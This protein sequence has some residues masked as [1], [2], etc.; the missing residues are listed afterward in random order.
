MLLSQRPKIVDVG[1]SYDAPHDIVS[2]LA[3][4]GERLCR[5]IAAR[6]LQGR[7]VYI[8]LAADIEGMPTNSWA[9]GFFDETHG[10][11]L[12]DAIG[13]RWRGPGVSLVID[14]RWTRFKA[15]D[16]SNLG[17]YRGFGPPCLSTLVRQCFYE[18][19]IHELAHGVVDLWLDRQRPLPVP[20]VVAAANHRRRVISQLARPVEE[21]MAGYEP[22]AQHGLSFIRAAACL[23]RR[24]EWVVRHTIEPIYG[25][26][27]YCLSSAHAYEQALSDELDH[28]TS[29]NLLD[30]LERDPPRAA[31]DLWLDDMKRYEAAHHSDLL[32]A[33]VPHLERKEPCDRN[34]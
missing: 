31:I 9:G 29:C 26:A 5:Q 30:L 10:V 12:R 4:R 33:D 19:T 2:D 18:T 16:R 14:A 8:T 6:E 20:T 32:A 13:R 11:G 22:W 7:P 23:A 21:M 28:A 15:I 17:A 34:L 1:A 27:R 24:A 25:G 3:A